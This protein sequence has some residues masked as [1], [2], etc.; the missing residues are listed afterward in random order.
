M[1]GTTGNFLSQPVHVGGAIAG[2]GSL[3]SAASWWKRLLWVPPWV[4]LF[5]SHRLRECALNG[6]A[7]NGNLCHPYQPVQCRS[8]HKQCQLLQH[9]CF[10]FCC[11]ISALVTTDVT[12]SPDQHKL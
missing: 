3:W 10:V 2:N 12:V 5:F 4:C 1:K 7:V 9:W 6:N 11:S 8:T